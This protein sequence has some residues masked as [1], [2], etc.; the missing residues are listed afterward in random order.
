MSEIQ[1]SSS[2]VDQELT[3][4]AQQHIANIE[5]LVQFRALH[6]EIFEA[7]APKV[8]AILTKGDNPV[9][10]V[11]SEEE[12]KE[13][14][15]TKPRKNKYGLVM[16]TLEQELENIKIG[17][18]KIEMYQGSTYIH[19]NHGKE[20]P[21]EF[22]ERVYKKYSDEDIVYQDDL[23][24]IDAKLYHALANYYS[25]IQKSP[26]N[27]FIPTSSTRIMRFIEFS[28]SSA[29]NSVHLSTT[30]RDILEKHRK[31]NVI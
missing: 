6:P 30:G 17:F 9:I 8:K 27:Q 16:E 11:L 19:P 1:K 7:I 13:Q 15:L 20:N 4:E 5:A 29:L 25:K 26:L 22:F 24:F 21:K 23:M 12:I 2:E 14:I 28:K 10:P 31:T 3:Q 18:L